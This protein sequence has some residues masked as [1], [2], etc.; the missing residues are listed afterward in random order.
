VET[1]S[2]RAFLS[3]L[4]C[5]V[6]QGFLF[7]PALPAPQFERWIDAHRGDAAAAAA[8]RTISGA[9]IP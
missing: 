8:A 5:D 1:E 7:S 2:Q 3:W 4:G 6:L 9:A